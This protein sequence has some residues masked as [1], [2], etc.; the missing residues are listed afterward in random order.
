MKNNFIKNAAKALLAVVLVAAIVEFTTA[1]TII[2]TSSYNTIAQASTAA[3]AGTNSVGSTN[4]NA[5]GIWPSAIGSNIVSLNAST[6]LQDVTNVTRIN[7]GAAKDVGLEFVGTLAGGGAGSA[8]SSNV[9][10]RIAY[11]D[12]PVGLAQISTNGCATRTPSGLFTWTIPAPLTAG[13]GTLDVMTNLSSSANLATAA[14][15]LVPTSHA[16]Y[17]LLDISYNAVTNG[18]P[19][20]TNYALYFNAK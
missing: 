4:V 8:F 14:L 17:Y 13:A 15:A 12:Q 3:F 20:L 7:I 1:A 5:Y 9:V 19:Y 16:N 18:A 6:L 11:D 2:G 10:V